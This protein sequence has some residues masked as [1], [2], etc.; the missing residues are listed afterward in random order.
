MIT[1][2]PHHLSARNP[3]AVSERLPDVLIGD[4]AR[5]EPQSMR[6]GEVGLAEGNTHGWDIYAATT[7]EQS[8]STAIL[9]CKRSIDRT[10]MTL[11]RAMVHEEPLGPGQRTT[12]DAHTLPL[13]EIRIWEN[14]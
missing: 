2:K 3:T 7:T 6:K 9:R 8:I 4:R 11:L 10:T 13:L 1:A 14:R 5:L 12:H